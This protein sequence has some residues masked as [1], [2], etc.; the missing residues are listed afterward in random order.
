VIRRRWFVT[1]EERTAAVEVILLAPD[2]FR[3]H[4]DGRD[5]AIEVT[6]LGRAGATTVAARGRVFSFFSGAGE[7][8]AH[9]GRER[10]AVSTRPGAFSNREAGGDDGERLVRAPMPGRVLKVLVTE[11]QSVNPGVPLAVVE[12]MKMENEL[13][14]S[15]A[16]IVKG[17]RVR[18]GDTVERDAAILEIE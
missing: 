4:V 6:L 15:R 11:G 16:G 9:P 5:E 8:V 13:V 14:A 10:L 7:L 1:R 18:A 3:V 17:V 12:A 2:R